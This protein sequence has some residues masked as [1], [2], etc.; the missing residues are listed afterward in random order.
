MLYAH[1]NTE[2]CSQCAAHGTF[3]G[4]EG[5]CQ[6]HQGTDL[7]QCCGGDQ[8]ATAM[9]LGSSWRSFHHGDAPSVLAPPGAFPCG[10]TSQEKRHQCHHTLA[11]PAAP[12]G[13]KEQ[14]QQLR[15][16]LVFTGAFCMLQELRGNRWQ[17][18]LRR[19]S[20]PC[21]LCIDSSLAAQDNPSH[22]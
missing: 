2:S 10:D 21:Q 13:G 9:V 15:P 3:L 16:G 17:R 6:C 4:R 18:L 1:K 12:M 5:G 11:L 7:N 19:S 20:I 14:P 8:R 22:S